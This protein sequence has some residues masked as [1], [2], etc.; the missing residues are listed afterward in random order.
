M[1]SVQAMQLNSAGEYMGAGNTV[2]PFGAELM[3]RTTPVDA[4]SARRTIIPTTSTE[5]TTQGTVAP[6]GRT[7]TMYDSRERLDTSYD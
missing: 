6:N 2:L 5:M 3:I 4:S 1:E 7:D